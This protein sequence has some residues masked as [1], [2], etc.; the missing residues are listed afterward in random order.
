[1]NNT[2]I[3]MKMKKIILLLCI[4]VPAALAAQNKHFDNLY[5]KYENKEGFTCMNLTGEMLAAFTMMAG[6]DAD[7]K[8]AEVLKDVSS[9][10]MVIT[11]ST[12]NAFFAD[13]E[14]AILNGEYKNIVSVNESGENNVAV[15]Q[16]GK[17][18]KSDDQ[19]KEMLLVV[20]ST[21]GESVVMSV[22]GK[23]NL[24]GLAEAFSNGLF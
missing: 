9:I 12:D 17:E 1:M 21:D 18:A 7:K 2:K 19:P 5:N 24:M 16:C 6:G 23:G 22:I 13:L 15:Y 4:L 8:A 10:K 11:K 14:N 20:R 3:Q